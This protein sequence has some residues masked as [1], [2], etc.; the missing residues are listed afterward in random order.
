MFL[1]FTYLF[2]ISVVRWRCCFR[3][4]SF[5]FCCRSRCFGM[6][7]SRLLPLIEQHIS[8]SGADVVDA[9][10]LRRLRIIA[11]IPLCI[12][13]AYISCVVPGVRRGWV[14]ASVLDD[15]T[16]IIVCRPRNWRAYSSARRRESVESL[17]LAR[18]FSSLKT[19]IVTFVFP[20]SIA[21]S[22]ALVESGIEPVS[23][24]LIV[25]H[26]AGVSF[27]VGSS[28]LMSGVWHGS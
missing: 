11:K 8:L 22:M 6:P 5:W 3:F 2:N 20:I 16:E 23:A 1:I 26:R 14:L 10:A 4:C 15:S 9:T 25:A 13:S 7:G 19:P 17:Q 24:T 27:G 28:G 21:R 18:R 12:S